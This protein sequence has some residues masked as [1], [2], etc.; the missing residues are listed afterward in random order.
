MIL[1]NSFYLVC[2]LFFILLIGGDLFSQQH[3]DNLIELSVD[4]DGI[5]FMVKTMRKQF[6][7]EIKGNFIDN[8]WHTVFIQYRLGNLTMDVDGE[9]TVILII[10]D[11]VGKMDNVI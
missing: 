7:E 10:I 2:F 9:I 3:N 1:Q 4:S 8:L 6:K 5:I 11:Y